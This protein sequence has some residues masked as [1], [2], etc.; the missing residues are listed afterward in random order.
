MRHRPAPTGSVAVNLSLPQLSIILLY[1]ASSASS[2]SLSHSCFIYTLTD[3]LCRPL[4]LKLQM[5]LL[6]LHVQGE[7]ENA[8]S[9][10]SAQRLLQPL[11]LP[12]LLLAVSLCA[13]MNSRNKRPSSL[14]CMT[15]I[16]LLC[17][18]K[19]K[20]NKQTK[21]TRVQKLFMCAPDASKVQS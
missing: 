12:N 19:Y 17:I 5:C 18:C 4:A 10:N 7:N 20:T 14:L 6:S 9:L 11:M 8:S 1:F 15:S 21:Q 3:E 2:P 16:L 13:A